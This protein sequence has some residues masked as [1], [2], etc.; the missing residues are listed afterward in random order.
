M[1]DKVNLSTFPS[2]KVSA[3]AMLYLQNQDLSKV[4]PEEIADLYN[5]TYF[6]IKTRFRESKKESTVSFLK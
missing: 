4:T 1:S 5:E 6:K 2:S 3:L